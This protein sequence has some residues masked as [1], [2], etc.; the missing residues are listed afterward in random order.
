RSKDNSNGPAAA[1]E[2][3]GERRPPTATVSVTG[4]ASNNSFGQSPASHS[5]SAEVRGAARVTAARCAIH[6]WSPSESYQ[7]APRNRADSGLAASIPRSGGRGEAVA[8]DGPF[9]SINVMLPAVI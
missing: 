1:S 8:G 2:A 5:F 9:Q 4:P 6:R 3:G 7:P